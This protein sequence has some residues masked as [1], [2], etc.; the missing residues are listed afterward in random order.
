MFRFCKDF[1]TCVDKLV[2]KGTARELTERKFNHLMRIAQLLCSETCRAA[3][4]FAETVRL[5]PAAPW[6][7]EYFMV[8]PRRWPPRASRRFRRADY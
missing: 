3:W 8:C 4:N 7:P 6:M 5:A 1:N 2:E